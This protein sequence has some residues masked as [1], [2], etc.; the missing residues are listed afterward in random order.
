VS[1]LAS[2][3]VEASKSQK[4]PAVIEMFAIVT[5]IRPARGTSAAGLRRGLKDHLDRLS[6]REI[7]IKYDAL[8]NRGL[9]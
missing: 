6:A 1:V 5:D 2:M 7:G 3:I 8:K 4:L 9:I